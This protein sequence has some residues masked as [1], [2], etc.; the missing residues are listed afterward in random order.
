MLVVGLVLVVAA[1]GVGGVLLARHNAAAVAI[2]AASQTPHPDAPP[3]VPAA[4]PDSVAVP[5]SSTAP[6]EPLD[7]TTAK[8]ALDDEVAQDRTAAEELVGSWVPQLSS[9]RPGLVADGITYD[10]PDIWTNFQELRAEYPNALLI[11]S[12]DYRSF[13]RSDFYVTVV[14]EP[15]SQG[16]SANQWC[17]TAGLAPAACYAKFLSHEGGS[18]GTTLLR[19]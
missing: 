10:Y 8:A 3:I 16:E 2:P 17:D 15:Y 14:P 19:H 5:P 1:A 6:D 11:W 18:S 7:D 12:G 4:P 9:K 13:Q